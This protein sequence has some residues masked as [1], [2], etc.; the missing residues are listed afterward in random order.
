MKDWGWYNQRRLPVKISRSGRSKNQYPKQKRELVLRKG[1][2]N[3]GG[4]EH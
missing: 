3:L 1:N 2:G 4:H